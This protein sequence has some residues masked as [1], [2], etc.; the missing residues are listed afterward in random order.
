[1]AGNSKR[2]GA[3]RKPGVKKPRTVGSGSERR[4]GLKGK[5]PTPK[6][7]DRVG[8]KAHRK[9]AADEKRSAKEATGKSNQRRKRVTTTSS[10]RDGADLV[11]GRNPVVEALAAKVPSTQLHVLRYI[12]SDP[13]VKQAMASALA[14][15][16]PILESS[17]NELDDLAE[18]LPHQGLALVV[19]PYTYASLSDLLAL[20]SER[21][22][23]LLVA[24]DGVTDPRNL[25][26]IARS[27]GAFGGHGIVIPSRRSA[28]V[29][30][31]AWRSS[32]GVLA[33]VPVAMVTNMSR[34]VEDAQNAGV[35]VVGLA[36][37]S[38]NS[39]DELDLNSSSV[40]IV[41][42]GE[43]RG[44]GRLVE[45]TCDLTAA[46]PISSKVESLNASVAAGIALHALAR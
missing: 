12:D 7:K 9:S 4:R 19:K 11:L 31:S 45:Q 36:G 23:L 35:T 16:I 14:L 40:M 15:G 43:G 37:D 25:G 1:M 26:A 39:I 27:V 8:H 22:P 34:A 29:T 21:D 28:G 38:D 6:A 10:R 5:G 30:A 33:H 13:R 42:G 18:G 41:I 24:L 3:V 2:K 44:L 32:A 17:R 20:D 46:I